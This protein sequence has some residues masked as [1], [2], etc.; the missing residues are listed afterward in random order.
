[1]V[2]KDEIRLYYGASNGTHN[3]WRDGFLCLATLRPDGFAGYE[4]EDESRP[5]TIVTRPVV[6][7]GST[8]RVTADA[9]GGSARVAVLGDDGR[10][11]AI[12]QLGGSNVTDAVVAFEGG[13]DLS[14]LRGREVRLEFVLTKAK[15]YA[16]SVGGAASKSLKQP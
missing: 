14:T 2:L 15:L 13:A 6:V 3:G 7:S 1:V 4:P 9:K 5:A 8:L 12:G 16:F 10:R 11:L